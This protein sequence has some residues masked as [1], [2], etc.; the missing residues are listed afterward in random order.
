MR[1]TADE[2]FRVYGIIGDN[3]DYSLS[4]MIY[5]TVFARHKINAVYNLYNLKPHDLPRFVELVRELGIAGFNVTTPFKQTIIPFLDRRGQRSPLPGAVNLVIQRRSQLFGFNTDIEGIRH[6]I[7]TRLKINVA[8]KD[9]VVFGSGGAAITVF[10]Y[11]AQKRA[12]SVT[13]IHRTR[14]SQKRFEESADIKSLPTSYYPEV[15]KVRPFDPLPH[16]LCINCTPAPLDTLVSPKA[17]KSLGAIFE[18]RYGDYPLLNRRHLRGNEMLAVQAA[19]NLRSMEGLNV[20]YLECLKIINKA[21]HD[22]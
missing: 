22:D 15:S 20:P 1:N 2:Q 5:N 8:D 17:L 7:E 4:P 16:D 19:S 10:S 18:L 3:I 13:V 9:I 12:R 14:R 21:L 11:L 6:S